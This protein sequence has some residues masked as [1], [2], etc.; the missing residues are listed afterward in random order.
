MY[1][2]KINFHPLQS[3]AFE[4]LKDNNLKVYS[5][6]NNN[7]DGRREF[8]VANENDFWSFYSNLMRNERH[9]YEII[10]ENSPCR[11]YFDL[12]VLIIYI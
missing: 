8:F 6:E 4:E 12:E 10:K 9:Y 1:F 11:L 3:Q 7:C 2:D 5:R